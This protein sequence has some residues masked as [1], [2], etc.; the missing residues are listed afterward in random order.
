MYACYITVYYLKLLQATKTQNFR[1]RKYPK[2]Y[3]WSKSITC[4][5]VKNINK[6]LKSN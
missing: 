4:W 3:Y 1:S 2:Y 6:I 5:S